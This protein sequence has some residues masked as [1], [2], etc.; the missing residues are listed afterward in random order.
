MQHANDQDPVKDES[1][2][3]SV[4]GAWRPILTDIVKAL[5]DG[6]CSL[7]RGVPGVASVVRA[8]A[9]QIRDYLDDYGETL[10][11][12]PEETWRSSTSQWMGAHWDVLVDLWT[13]ESGESDLV[14]SL[15][16]FEVEGGYQFEIH[17]VYVP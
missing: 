13:L 2:A 4:A 7:S 3:H 16:V 14:L 8:T 9:E 17:S 12:L 11:D 5:A 15:R 10:V 6:D 1:R